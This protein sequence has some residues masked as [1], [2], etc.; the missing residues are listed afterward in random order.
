MS[1]KSMSAKLTSP[2][3]ALVSRL[4][5]LAMTQ[6][7]LARRLGR[8]TPIINEIVKGRTT[9]TADMALQLAKVL[10]PKS[11]LAESAHYWL[12]IGAHYSLEEA[13]KEDDEALKEETAKLDINTFRD[14][15]KN[16]YIQYEGSPKDRLAKLKTLLQFFGVASLK[17]LTEVGNYDAAFRVGKHDTINKL[18]LAAWLRKGELEALQVFETNKSIRF[19]ASHLLKAVKGLRDLI[20]DGNVNGLQERVQERLLHAG[21]ILVTVPH[22]KGTYAN[23]AAW[24]LTP[25]IAVVQLSNRGG[26]VDMFWFNLFHKIAHLLLH[27]KRSGQVTLERAELY[28]TPEAL[29]QESEANKFARDTLIPEVEYVDFTSNTNFSLEAIEAFAE[30]VG[31]HKGI[32]IGRLQYDG[33]LSWSKYAG[34]RLKLS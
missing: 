5:Y 27:G 8:S 18:A 21:V 33:F 9:I 25:K 2:S 12:Q 20:R 11:D 7:E 6:A 30:Q 22:L 14:L 24:W 3:A 28:D 4:E 19:K 32:V 23:G 15:A 17:S 29:R 34:E 31:V 26:Y 1:K 10:G 16:G 13:V